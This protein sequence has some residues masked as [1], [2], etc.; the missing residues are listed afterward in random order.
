MQQTGMFTNIFNESN[1]SW[2][3]IDRGFAAIEERF[4][5]SLAAV[6]EHA[7]LAVL[8]RDKTVARKCFDRTKGKID[9]SVWR[10]PQ[11]FMQFAYWAY[12]G[13]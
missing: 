4:P 8:A 3:R 1:L 6:S 11:H 13:N 9:L 10:S 12:D 2:P 7:H 5:D